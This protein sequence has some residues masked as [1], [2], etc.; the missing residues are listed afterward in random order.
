MSHLP[1]K[2][3]SALNQRFECDHF[4]GSGGMGVVWLAK[5]RST[6]DSVAIK[7]LLDKF[8]AKAHAKRRFLREAEALYRL[9]HPNIVMLRDFI[10]SPPALVMKYIK[11]ESL[12]S[13]RGQKLSWSRIRNIFLQILDALAFAHSRGVIHRDLKPENI[14]LSKDQ[15]Q[16]EMPIIV[17]FGLAIFYEADS[18]TKTR[19]E[20]QAGTLQYM[21][22]EQLVGECTL[23]HF[24]DI[25]AVGIMI[26]E[27]ICG[28]LPWKSEQFDELI[29]LKKSDPRTF[30]TH[31]E[32]SENLKT[33][34]LHSLKPIPISRPFFASEIRKT[35]KNL[36]SLVFQEK[37]EKLTPTTIELAV[38]IPLQNQL[39]KTVLQMQ[40]GI[41]SFVS[42]FYQTVVQN[43]P[44]VGRKKEKI[45]LRNLIE[46]TLRTTQITGILLYGTIGIGKS[47]LLAWLKAEISVDGK[48][49]PILV[50]AFVDPTPDALK[51][52][53]NQAM[54]CFSSQRAIE[55]IHGAL[56]ELGVKKEN[57]F[58]ELTNYLRGIRQ[59][60]EHTSWRHCATILYLLSQ[61]HPICLIV[62]GL[63][64][65]VHTKM[66][67]FLEWLA[68]ENLL[69]NQPIAIVAALRSSM[70]IDGSVGLERSWFLD[71]SP[72]DSCDIDELSDSAMLELLTSLE[73]QEAKKVVK[74]LMGNPLLA[75]ETMWSS[76]IISLPNDSLENR[77]RHIFSRKLA[78]LRLNSERSAEL[79]RFLRGIS[80][81]PARFTV[82]SLTK[83]L[84]KAWP[85]LDLPKFSS[86]LWLAIGE[87]FIVEYQTANSTILVFKHELLREVIRL[88]ASEWEEFSLWQLAWDAALAVKPFDPYVLRLRARI[89]EGLY[90]SEKRCNF[91]IKAG[92][93]ALSQHD[94]NLAEHCFVDARELSLHTDQ[95]AAALYG[96]AQVASAM[97]R[98]TD[99][100]TFVSKAIKNMSRVVNITLVQALLLK[101]KS[102]TLLGQRNS[103]LLSYQVALSTL[104]SI[105]SLSKEEYLSS[106]IETLIGLGGLY[107]QEKKFKKATRL[108][109]KAH[110]MS[111]KIQKTIFFA[112][113]LFALAQLQKEKGALEQ[114]VIFLA[115]ANEHYQKHEHLKG[116]KYCLTARAFLA[117]AKKEHEQARELFKKAIQNARKQGDFSS[118]IINCLNA[119]SF[120]I[121]CKNT[122]KATQLLLLCQPS[123]HQ[124]KW[125]LLTIRN[126]IIKAQI[127]LFKMYF[128]DAENE[129]HKAIHLEANNDI[130]DSIIKEGFFDCARHFAKKGYRFPL[131]ADR[132]GR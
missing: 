69:K 2:W 45:V 47:R 102:L 35:I 123:L 74:T 16:K 88:S 115:Q 104:N 94:F 53:L 50:D 87:K 66:I 91:L 118:M 54:G 6:G 67:R 37:L 55:P 26:Y 75:I 83:V 64:E 107:T 29:Q 56:K 36:T 109:H 49:F 126:H 61:K 48:F 15:D 44:M 57:E 129:L 33:L 70:S 13:L 19:Y 132:L 89:S 7:I 103:A 21:A 105:S 24:V 62:D 32:I 116:L 82:E 114:A 11:G 119:A 68:T 28:I 42:P 78:E 72:L 130:Q 52:A 30:S 92:K 8:T 14:L 3:P 113:T 51:F 110:N 43:A 34:I 46:K 31:L 38:P 4:L 1:Y 71:V 101:A 81:G 40:K 85:K 12:A 39:H 18:S 117:I 121:K 98:Y 59:E 84:S 125:P 90:S 93:I 100:V 9:R 20:N 128:K 112:D 124:A 73:V 23:T 65:L 111:K 22:L 97:S 79:E 122:N 41:T 76:S 131:L 120:E 127:L 5:E 60:S 17:D 99:A 25:H 86:L 96:T 58:A 106:S 27:F 108:L 95:N 10:S 80:I 77:L 63:E